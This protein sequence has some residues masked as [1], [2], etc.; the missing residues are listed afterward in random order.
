MTTKQQAFC[1]YYLISL[2]ATEAAKKAGYSKKTC[3][4][5]GSENLQKLELKKY[6]DERL[7]KLSEKRFL[8]LEEILINLSDIAINKTYELRDRLKAYD[9]IL[10]RYPIE[11]MEKEKDE[12][13]RIIIQKESD[14]IE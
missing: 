11:V 2:N 10:R 12:E 9:L 7:K 5:I 8:S 14:V 1:D 6:I 3:T 4:K 13:I